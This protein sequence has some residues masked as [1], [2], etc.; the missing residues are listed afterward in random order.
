MEELAT[1]CSQYVGLALFEKDMKLIR[2]IEY[3][4]SDINLPGDKF[5]FDKTM[6]RNSLAWYAEI[7]IFYCI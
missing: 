2:Q 4:F 5:L 3:Y 6:K 7:L 1:R